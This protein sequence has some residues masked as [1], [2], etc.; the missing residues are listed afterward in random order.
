MN[1]QTGS[2]QAKKC[3]VL[4]KMPEKKYIREHLRLIDVL[5]NPSKSKLQKELKEQ[6]KELKDYQAKRRL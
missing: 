3:D 4:V 5:R 1:S 6:S 2:F